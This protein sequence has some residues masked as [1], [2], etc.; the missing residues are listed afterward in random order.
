APPELELLSFNT[1]AERRAAFTG[2]DSFWL[3]G[4]VRAIMEIKDCDA[5][6]A[7]HIMHS[8]E[9]RGLTTK[10]CYRQMQAW[11]GE[12]ILVDKTPSYALDQTVLE[13]AEV[14]FENA[15][16][17]HLLRHP[18]GMIRS[19]EEAK[20]DQIFFRYEHA[21]SRRELAEVIWTLSHQNIIEFLHRVPRER[22]HRV[23]FEDLLREPQPVME[24]LCRFLGL[25]LHPD[26][27]QPY[28]G[29]ERRMTDGIHA[30][31]R[32]LGDVKF[33]N[34]DRIDVRAGDRWKEGD[35]QRPLGEVTYELAA[36][37]GYE[38]EFPLSFAQ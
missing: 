38:R 23:K 1:L 33:H 29:I 31:S 11:L 6:E 13:R 26:M 37:L 9:E 36:V 24:S 21:F 18:A 4:T 7:Q 27:L 28:K 17:V 12:R 25:D 15:L 20:L 32:M 2:K 22:Q 3:E 19:F 5:D 34:Y 8:M 35:A 10:A 14:D 30:E 16:Y